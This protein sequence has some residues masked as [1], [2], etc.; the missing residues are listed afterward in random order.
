MGCIAADSDQPCPTPVTEVASCPSAPQCQMYTDCERCVADDSCAFCADQN[1]CLTVSEIFEVEGG[2]RGTVFD[3]P[4][5]DSFI[6][7]NRVVGNLIV[8]SDPTFGGGEFQID[9]HSADGAT[10]WSAT[11][12]EDS[13]SLL[14]ASSVAISGGNLSTPNSAGGSI[15]LSAGDGVNADRGT[16]GSIDI[17]AGDGYGQEAYGVPGSAGGVALKAGA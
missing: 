7:V 2:C 17:I 5:P 14:A 4:C 11:L 16:G 3:A 12:A 15:L 9:G 1:L 8:E 13:F 6:G 10:R